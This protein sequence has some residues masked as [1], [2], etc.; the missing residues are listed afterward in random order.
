MAAE[1]ERALETA[2]KNRR[3]ARAAWNTRKAAWYQARD[4][5]NSH[6]YGSTSPVPP[7]YEKLDAENSALLR[8]DEAALK[9]FV[10]TP[11]PDH[12]ALIEK[13]QILGVEGLADEHLD[14][15]IADVRA[16]EGRVTIDG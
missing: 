12:S 8:L 15:L 4:A 14:N 3:E 16:L 5:C 11:T 9:E 10:A 2:N 7:D 1:R 6:P 13:I